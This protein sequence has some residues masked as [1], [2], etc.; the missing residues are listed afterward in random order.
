[1]V[2]DG[3]FREDLY[4]RLNVVQ[5]LMPPLCER[6]EDI[7]ELA[8]FYLQEYARNTQTE[9]RKL[10]IELLNFLC[11]YNWPGSI[12]QLKNCLESM[13][14]LSD[15]PELGLADMPPDL[16]AVAGVANWQPSRHLDALKK[17]AILQ[18]LQSHGGNRTRTAEFLGISVRT[19][20]RKIQEWGIAAES[21][22]S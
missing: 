2:K 16:R 19:L 13:C 14:T 15:E 10:N 3:T 1:M 7:P 6:R 11:S 4:Y 8:D 17:Q 9:P 5:L 20:Q 22:Q 12:R 21:Q 18:A